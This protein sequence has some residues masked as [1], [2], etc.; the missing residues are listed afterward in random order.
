MNLVLPLER[1]TVTYCTTIC[2]NYSKYMM[3]EKT[4][5]SIKQASFNISDS[6][7]NFIF[8]F[9]MAFNGYKLDT[10]SLRQSAA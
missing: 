7:T 4:I 5:K 8:V 3:L 9:F 6:G 10:S 2:F 1:Y